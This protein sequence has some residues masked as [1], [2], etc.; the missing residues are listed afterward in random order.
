M[1]LTLKFI[2]IFANFAGWFALIN[3]FV[4]NY[5]QS[6]VLFQALW[7]TV[8]FVLNFFGLLLHSFYLFQLI[9]FISAGY[10]SFQACREKDFS[11]LFPKEFLVLFAICFIWF[12]RTGFAFYS[13]PD[14][15]LNWG[16]IIKELTLF[17]GFS[18][19]ELTNNAQPV[20]PNGPAIYQYYFTKFFG[21]SQGIAILANCCL[22][23]MLCSF[24]LYTS[25]KLVSSL[26]LIVIITIPALYLNPGFGSLYADYIVGASFAAL[27]VVI[28]QEIN[29]PNRLLIFIPLIFAM[30]ALKQVGLT[31]SNLTVI[32]LV[33]LMFR[34]KLFHLSYI[35]FIACLLILPQIVDHVWVNEFLAKYVP[36]IQSKTF[37]EKFDIATTQIQT[38]HG[39]KVTGNFLLAF[40]TFFFFRSGGVIFTSF[41]LIA[42]I[43][44]KWNASKKTFDDFK[45]VFTASIIILLLYA[46]DTTA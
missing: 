26:L 16:I 11:S 21:Y 14:E 35:L 28:Y 3:K 31:L 24:L 20:Y 32:F 9:G 7:I 37:L 30:A 41:I 2:L 46:N 5:W 38:E 27:L 45:I 40:F 36:D 25:K 17:D 34:R 15:T 33:Y 10:F 8:G 1:I 23:T 39:L 22:F 13:S 19:P 12:L 6:I 29:H 18:P 42:F 44:I 4:K 43:F